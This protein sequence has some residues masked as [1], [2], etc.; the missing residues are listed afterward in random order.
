MTSNVF[1]SKKLDVI[2]VRKYLGSKIDRERERERER[3]RKRG[4]FHSDG[5]GIHGAHTQDGMTKYTT[6][7]CWYNRSYMQWMMVFSIVCIMILVFLVFHCV[8]C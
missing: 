3:E 6:I 2:I 1:Y 4:L 7:V 8:S 5:V